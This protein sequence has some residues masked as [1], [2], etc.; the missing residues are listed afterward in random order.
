MENKST[1]KTVTIIILLLAVFGLGGYIVYDKVTSNDKTIKLK[2]EIKSLKTEIKQAKDLTKSENSSTKKINEN[3]NL[4]C[5]EIVK[6]SK[7]VVEN[8]GNDGSDGG[9]V[10]EKTSITFGNDNTATLVEGTMGNGGNY[11]IDGSVI[12]FGL[13]GE[14]K[15]YAIISQDCKT[16]YTVDTQMDPAVKIYEKK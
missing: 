3:Q 8:S 13:V 7:Y 11:S 4:S 6:G 16:I 1:G 10:T 14:N 12:T 15:T 5:S 9:P 2:N